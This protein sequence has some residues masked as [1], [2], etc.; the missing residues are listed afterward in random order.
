[1]I[2]GRCEGYN[3]TNEYILVVY[4]HKQFKKRSSNKTKQNDYDT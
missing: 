1:M 4:S 2:K 3:T